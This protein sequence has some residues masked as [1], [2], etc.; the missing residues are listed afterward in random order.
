MTKT[1]KKRGKK[2]KTFNFMFRVETKVQFK[3]SMFLITI[4]FSMYGLRI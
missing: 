4:H 3:Q 1:K 2:N